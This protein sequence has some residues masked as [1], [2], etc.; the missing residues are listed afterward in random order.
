[1]SAVADGKV[2]PL[3]VTDEALDVEFIPEVAIFV[4]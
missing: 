1:M 3:V 4:P 2:L